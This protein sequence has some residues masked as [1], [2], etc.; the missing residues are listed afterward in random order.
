MHKRTQCRR[1]QLEKHAG[2]GAGMFLDFETDLRHQTS[3][4]VEEKE[5]V[6]KKNTLFFLPD[7]FL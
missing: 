2:E 3:N 6:L 5:K 4:T 7:S 1:I